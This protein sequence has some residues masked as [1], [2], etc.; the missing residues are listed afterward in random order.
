MEYIASGWW[1]MEYI[2][3]VGGRVKPA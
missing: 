2:A 1:T 3:S